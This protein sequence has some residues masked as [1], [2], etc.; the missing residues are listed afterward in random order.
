M[1]KAEEWARSHSACYRIRD[2][3]ITV[4]EDALSMLVEDRDKLRDLLASAVS[5]EQ[6]KPLI[7]ALRG[8]NYDMGPRLDT[9]LFPVEAGSIRKAAQALARARAVGMEDKP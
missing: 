2:E 1:T 9:D 5:R 3:Y 7:E 6:V 8:F 4:G